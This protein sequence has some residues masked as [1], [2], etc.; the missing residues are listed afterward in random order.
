MFYGLMSLWMMFCEWMQATA[1]SSWCKMSLMS[2][3]LSLMVI[4][5]SPSMTVARHCPW[6]CSSMRAQWCSSTLKTSQI[7][8]TWSQLSVFK[9]LISFSR[10]ALFYCDR[11]TIFSLSGFYRLL[12]YFMANTLL[13]SCLCILQTEEKLPLPISSSILQWSS[14]ELKEILQATWER[15]F[16]SCSWLASKYLIY[17]LIRYIYIYKH[18]LVFDPEGPLLVLLQLPVEDVL[19]PQVE[20]VLGIGVIELLLFRVLCGTSPMAM[21]PWSTCTWYSLSLK[22]WRLKAVKEQVTFW[23]AIGSEGDC[24]F[25]G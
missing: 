23:Q 11:C 1:L 10:R 16:N 13:S 22:R 7:L 12:T 19:E 24:W 15:N 17:F 6:R 14:R 2:C 25:I 20:D 9:M 8:I 21:Q 3:S 4:F 18:L 5:F